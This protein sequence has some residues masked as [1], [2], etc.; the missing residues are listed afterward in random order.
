MK[1]LIQQL[2]PYLRRYRARLFSGFL[3]IFAT[4]AFM[5]LVPWL[6]K[7]AIDDLKGAVETGAG[8]LSRL[9]LLGYA[10]IIVGAA[11][12]GG[13]FRFLMR[14]L[15]IGASRLIEYDLRNDLFAHLQ[16]LSFAYYNRTKTGDLMARATNDLNAVRMFLGPGIMYFSQTMILLPWAFLLMMM[17]SVKLTLFAVIPMPLLALFAFWFGRAV[18]KR[19]MAVQTQYAALNARVQENLAGIR[20]VKAYAREDHEEEVFDALSRDLV[21]KNIDLVKVWG[22]FFPFMFFMSG[23]SMVIVLWLGGRQVIGGA[24]TLGDFVAFSG[25]LALLTWPVVSIGWVLNLVQQGAASMTRIRTVMDEKPDIDDRNVSGDHAPLAGGIEFRAVTFAYGKDREPVLENIDLEIPAGR[26]VAIVGR[27]GSGKTSLV[28]L[29]PR[30]FDPTSGQVLID[31]VDVREIPLADLRAHIGMVPQE[32]FLFSEKIG[33]NIAFGD[34]QASREAVEN[35]AQISRIA[36]DLADFPKGY[37]TVV[38]ERGVTLSGGQKQRTAIAR[39]LIRNPRIL[40]LDDAL[41]SVD[42]YTEEKI[43]SGLRGFMKGRTSIIISHRIS[44]VK[45]A[46]QI[47]VLEGGGI[48]E[49]GDHE[50]LLAKG[51]LYA[52]IYQKQLLE[53]ELEAS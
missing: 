11:L 8:D 37:D 33:E 49:Q 19:F 16:K 30:L 32:T 46:D 34:P 44:T 25:Y 3:C 15:M 18:H 42:T 24:I 28:Q 1:S 13:F 41:S 14:Y 52:E 31:G 48:A 29:V 6:L 38:G 40:I 43:L 26:T 45:E 5:L 17:L 39:A 9:S 12:V 51:G 21:G 27:T 23:I 2:R 35:A 22:L 47:V 20:V 10:G 4:T 50:T 53:E 36:D 7:L